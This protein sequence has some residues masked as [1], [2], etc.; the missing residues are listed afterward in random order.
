MLTEAEAVTKECRLNGMIETAGNKRFPRC[1]AS[2]C[3]GWEWKH[4]GFPE[5]R[6]PFNGT[7]IA[8]AVPAQGE[9][10]YKGK[11]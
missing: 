11:R 10:G 6:S 2:Q 5:Y 4:L 7:V 8:Q 1:V 3:M 9:C